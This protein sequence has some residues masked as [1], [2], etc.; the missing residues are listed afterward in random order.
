MTAG[1]FLFSHLIYRELSK[2]LKNVN[3]ILSEKQTMEIKRF[4]L[5]VVAGLAL[6]LPILQLL[7]A[8]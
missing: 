2:R 5:F 4:L 6:Y 8:L 7:L 1:M 3:V